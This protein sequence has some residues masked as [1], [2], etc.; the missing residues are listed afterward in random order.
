M[1][2]N[3]EELPHQACRSFCFSQPNKIVDK[4]IKFENLP[5]LSF[6]FRRDQGNHLRVEDRGYYFELF[7]ILVFS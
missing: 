7:M 4:D 1:H 3:V 6:P 5:F 2:E